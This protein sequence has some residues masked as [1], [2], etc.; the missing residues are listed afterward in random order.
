MMRGKMADIIKRGLEKESEHN[1]TT[2]K[3]TQKTNRKHNP[4]V[5]KTGSQSKSET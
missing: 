4:K 3:H 2:N 5:Y 1:F